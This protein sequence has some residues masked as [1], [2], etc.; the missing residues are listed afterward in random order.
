M[1]TDYILFVHGVN[2]RSDDYADEL[3]DLIRSSTSSLHRKLEKIVLY[4][5]D[6][7]K[8]QEDA[9]LKAYKASPI[10]KKFWFRELR[11]TQMMQFA[12]DAALYLSRYVG[13][14][15]AKLF[16]EK[17]IAALGNHQEKDRLHLVTHSLGTV[18]LFDMLFSARWDQPGMPGAE[19]VAIIRQ[20]IFGVSPDPL[21]GIRLGSISTMGSPI[22]IFSLMDVDQQ[23]MQDTTNAQGDVI[24]THDITPRLTQL[25][26]SLHDEL[27]I[28]LPWRNY[29]HPGDPVAYPLST[30]LPTMVDN[31]GH[32]LDVQDLLTHPADLSD[33]LTEP[34]SQTLLAM[35]HGG[36]AH[37][38]YWQSKEVAHKIAQTIRQVAKNL[39]AVEVAK[40]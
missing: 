17:G 24:C 36:A 10:W 39:D 28:M 31:D 33:F 22:G 2:I 18:I 13:A 37:H 11:E 7:N 38:S 30:L 25:L 29:V 27:G 3:F 15:V 1:A 32:Y 16:V 5:G 12:G 14:K 23:S 35:L 8:E 21:A 6:V 9:L 4:W 34:F 19:S 26:K 20:V 40:L